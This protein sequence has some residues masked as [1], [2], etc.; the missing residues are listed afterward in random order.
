M[1]S[2]SF[3][4]RSL[5]FYNLTILKSIKNIIKIRELSASAVDLL[6]LHYEKK[7]GRVCFIETFTQKFFFQKV[8]Y[9]SSV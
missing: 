8:L 4:K 3:F 5:K 6:I 2:F 7:I 9:A 1:V